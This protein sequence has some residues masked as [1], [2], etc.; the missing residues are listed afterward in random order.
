M[1]A[2]ND[3]E[4]AL[5]ARMADT[6]AADRL[7]LLTVQPFTG[8]LTM[9]L[10]LIPVVDDRL[11]TA[12]TDGDRIFVNADFMARRSAADRRFILAHEVWHCALGHHRRRQG[13]EPQ[14]WNQACDY[15]VNARCRELLNHC[16]EDALFNRRYRN[17]S[18]E[19]IY[20]RL[21][22]DPDSGQQPLDEHDLWGALQQ[23]DASVQDPD[24]RPEHGEGEQQ[25]TWER[26]LI[27][28]AQRCRGAGDLPAGIQHIVDRIR[29]PTV[30]WPRLLARF[31]ENHRGGDYQ[32]LPPSRRHLHRGL[33]LPARR[34]HRLALTVALDAS[35]SCRDHIPAFMSELAEIL[36]S[37]D[38]V[39][40]RLLVFDTA[41]QQDEHFTRDDLSRLHEVRVRGGGGTDFQPVFEAAA[42]EG[43]PLV[44]L[45]DGCGPAQAKAPPHPVLWALTDTNTAPVEW[46][47]TARIEKPGSNGYRA[48]A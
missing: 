5:K 2:P 28:A 30:P 21:P 25:R 6:L 22:Q 20:Q 35:G 14:R 37:F 9:Q 4:Q 15:E 18:A 19:A 39:A 27:G 1:R 10:E 46:G 16:P 38:E 31:V 13:R 47:E 26:R 12:G 7:L 40:L 11:P 45:T 24:F 8:Q 44:L 32:W 29:T 41:I 3:E 23:G 42:G 43:V 34:G 48:S 17:Q 33:Y 36:G